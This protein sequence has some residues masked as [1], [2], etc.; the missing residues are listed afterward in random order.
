MSMSFLLQVFVYNISVFVLKNIY[1][2][3]VLCSASKIPGLPINSASP[4]IW[5][6]LTSLCSNDEVL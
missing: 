2:I 4:S 1:N 5:S 6:L 3:S